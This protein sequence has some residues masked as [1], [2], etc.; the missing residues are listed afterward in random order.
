MRTLL[1]ANELSEFLAQIAD[2]VV[3]EAG[4]R[5]V[6]ASKGGRGKRLPLELCSG[7]SRTVNMSSGTFSF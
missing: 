4:S 5:G 1:T 2:I 6:A 7:S 3:G